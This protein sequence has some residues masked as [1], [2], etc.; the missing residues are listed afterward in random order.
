MDSLNMQMKFGRR[1][2]LISR[3]SFFA[4]TQDKKYVSAQN[5]R[6]PIENVYFVLQKIF[7]RTC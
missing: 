1:K 2:I 5:E 3:R 7:Y 6:I 4:S